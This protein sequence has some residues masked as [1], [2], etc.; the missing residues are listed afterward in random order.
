[1]IRLTLFAVFSRTKMKNKHNILLEPEK[2]PSEIL[3]LLEQRD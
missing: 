3:I 2:S 1:M